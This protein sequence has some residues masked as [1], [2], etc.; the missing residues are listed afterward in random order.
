[1]TEGHL[2][3]SRETGRLPHL[4]GFSIRKPAAASKRR[5]GD[6]QAA[7]KHAWIVTFGC[8]HLEVIA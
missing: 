6:R 5:D 7:S 4:F 8:V 1:M 3:G 2:C